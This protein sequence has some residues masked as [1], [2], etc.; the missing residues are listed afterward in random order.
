MEEW[1]RIMGEIARSQHWNWQEALAEV[2]DTLEFRYHFRKGGRPF[3]YPLNVQEI[4]EQLDRIEPEIR[5][6]AV[7]EITEQT[8]AAM[9]RIAN[10]FVPLH[11]DQEDLEGIKP[12]Q[13]IPGV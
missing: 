8:I 10:E 1:V 2:K 11:I 3:P 4:I 6:I 12:R 7:A 9:D 5:R 13:K